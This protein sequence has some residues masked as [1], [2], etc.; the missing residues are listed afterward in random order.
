MEQQNGSRFRKLIEKYLDNNI[1]IDE[2]EELFQTYD[3]LGDSEKD[4]KTQELGDQTT[5]GTDLL[6]RINQTLK[7]NAKKKPKYFWYKIAASILICSGILSAVYLITSQSTKQNYSA[8]TLKLAN[9]DLVYLDDLKVGAQVEGANYI[10]KKDSINFIS[11]LPIDN[12]D[13]GTGENELI[14]PKASN[15]KIRFAEGTTVTLNTSSSLKFPHHFAKNARVVQLNG[16][17]YFDVTK[18]PGKNFRVI[19]NKQII[20]VLGTRFNVKAFNQEPT[21]TTL[22]EGKVQ[23]SFADKNKNSQS[24]YLKPNQQAALFGKNIKISE[25][26][27]SIALAW[28]SDCFEF[29][30]DNIKTIMN[31]LQR[32]HD[33]EVVYKGN[34]D[35]INISGRISRSK[36][37]SEIIKILNMTDGVNITLEGRRIL[38]QK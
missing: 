24:Y 17:A 35:D 28:L 23:L 16:E 22:L 5:V 12:E 6:N 33:V 18:N 11:Y 2:Q 37:L 8:V 29:H 30:N 4:W 21:I 14:L 38:V 19:S 13:S 3:N 32:Y 10:I 34:V 36:S 20:Q 9:G 1:S 15:Y 27:T 25:V 7:I 26:D 31:E